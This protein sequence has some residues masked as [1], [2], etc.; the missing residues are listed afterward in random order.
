MI[1]ENNYIFLNLATYG[2]IYFYSLN[3][4]ISQLNYYYIYKKNVD[5][6]S[7]KYFNLN[8]VALH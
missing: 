7:I 5:N 8:E 6:Y 3:R 2:T 4:I 1:N